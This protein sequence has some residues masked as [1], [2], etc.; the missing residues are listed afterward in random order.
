M[1]LVIA[2]F[3]ACCYLLLQIVAS[4]YAND[5]DTYVAVIASACLVIS[6]F[7]SVTGAINTVHPML[8]AIFMKA[9]VDVLLICTMILSTTHK[10]IMLQR[11]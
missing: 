1:Q 4:P 10:N 11:S 6:L 9:S 2:S 3:I 7:A 5:S 8:N